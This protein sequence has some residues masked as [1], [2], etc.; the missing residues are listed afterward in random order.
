MLARALLPHREPLRRHHT[1][2][3]REIDDKREAL[4]VGVGGLLALRRRTV[5]LLAHSGRV[6][7][8][9]GPLEL[10]VRPRLG[11]AVHEGN[12]VVLLERLAQATLRVSYPDRQLRRAVD[13]SAAPEGQARLTV[14]VH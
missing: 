8:F 13:M 9:S 14:R 7:D 2:Y 10:E 4:L 6:V 5:D 1:V 12:A 11:V 3:P